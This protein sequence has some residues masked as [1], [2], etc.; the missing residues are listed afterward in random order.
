MKKILIVHTNNFLSGRQGENI[1]VIQLVSAFKEIGFIV[2]F[3]GYENFGDKPAFLDF[4]VQN[5]EKNLINRLYLYDCKSDVHQLSL[6]KR[7]KRKIRHIKSNTFLTDWA[8]DNAKEKFAKIVSEND[9]DVIAL[10]YSYQA[11]LLKD[12]QTKAKKVYFMEDSMFLQ[13]YSWHAKDNKKLTL[14]KLLDE[15]LERLNYFDDFFCISYDEKIFYEKLTEKT[16]EF[17]PH[18]QQPQ[19][20]IITPVSQ[21]K[22]DV[23][24][25]GFDNP[26][27]VEGLNWFFQEVYQYLSP[28]LN[29][30]LVGSAINKIQVEHENVDKIIFVPDLDEVM[31]NVKV[32]ICPMFRGTGMKIKVVEAMAKGLP[33]VCNERGVDGLP[34]KTQCGCL[35]TQDAKQFAAYINQLIADPEYYDT[36]SLKVSQYYSKVFDRKKYIEILK[37]KLERV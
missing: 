10:F 3:F 11:N 36:V 9:Y 18:L 33:V 8:Y 6:G 31:E 1:R 12:L 7:I 37:R 22:W 35:V 23:F 20:P 14:G 5:K 29:I 25:V 17:L 34:D 21:R 4:K 13:Q 2:D 32:V 30:L 27:N 16:M 26:F 19:P 24:F 15:E 28:E